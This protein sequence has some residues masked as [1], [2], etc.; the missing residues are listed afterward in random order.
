MLR[1][2]LKGLAVYRTRTFVPNE[3]ENR[4]DGPRRSVAALLD[5]VD[6]SAE[7]FPFIAE[8]LAHMRDAGIELTKETVAIAVQLG[9]NRHRRAKMCLSASPRPVPA[10]IVYYIRRSDLIKIG[11]T[12]NP[13]RR[14]R[15]LMPDEI[16]AFEPG[17]YPEEL[18]RHT[19][20]SRCRV[21]RRVE[22][23]HQHPELLEHIARLRE[24][25]GPPDPQWPSVE[26]LGAGLPRSRERIV[27][28]EPVSGE[29]VTA[30][31]GARMLG[32]AKS[33]I[34]GWA[35]RQL[36]PSCGLSGDKG[37]NLYYVEHL[38]FLRERHR[39]W[40]ANIEVGETGSLDSD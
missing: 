40:L 17:G 6:T 31:E 22:Y 34:Y 36:L 35:H 28:P 3:I 5:M 23:F 15:S 8:Q 32:I 2:L 26:T 30:T 9:E 25:H 39:P 19:Q 14:F 13:Q 33:T 7:A 37:L 38:R 1:T 20:F 29:R 24:R 4:Q 18:A 16:L 12:I 10:S 21:G 11:T 27:L